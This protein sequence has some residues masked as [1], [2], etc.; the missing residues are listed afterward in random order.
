MNRTIQTEKITDSVYC[1]KIDMNEYVF[2]FNMSNKVVLRELNRHEF[3][4][5]R[6]QE[7]LLRCLNGMARR[8]Q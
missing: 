1:V 4:S 3:L 6:E 2:S 7:E 8:R 5:K